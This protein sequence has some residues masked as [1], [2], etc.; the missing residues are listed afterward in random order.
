MLF[1]VAVMLCDM[2]SQMTT[3]PLNSKDQGQGHIV[4]AMGHLVRIFCSTFFMKQ[5]SLVALLTIVL[6]LLPY[7]YK[8]SDQ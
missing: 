2:Q 6:A 8:R 4:N 1:S 5:L 3:V 7:F